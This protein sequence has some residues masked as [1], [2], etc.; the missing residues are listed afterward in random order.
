MI[1]LS[2]TAQQ[3]TVPHLLFRIFSCTS[4]TR[5]PAR[6]FQAGGCG[7]IARFRHSQACVRPFLLTNM[8]WEKWRDHLMTFA[9]QV[10]IKQGDLTEMTTDAIVNAANN[11]LQLGGGVAGA[12][13]R[14]GGPQIQSECDQIGTIPVGGAA[15][16]SGGKLQARHVIHAAS[17]QLGGRT[18]AHALRSSTAHSLR[19]AAQNGLK[20]IAFPAVGTG[21]AG[22][23]LRECAEI[24]LSE[25]GKHLE[26]PTSIE[27]IYFVLFDKDAQKLFDE[28]F[29]EMTEKKS[30]EGKAESAD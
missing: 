21:I 14:K 3:T 30:R 5:L 8:A 16:T 7:F 26:G 25:A 9:N 18:S 27:K 22:F 24:M 17:M 6:W 11:D 10:E 4:L 20:T 1:P 2:E 12:I 23:P 15:I 29:R 28:V 13:R 19:I